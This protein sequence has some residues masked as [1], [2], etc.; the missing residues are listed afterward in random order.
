[1][2]SRADSDDT[3]TTAGAQLQSRR[4][5]LRGLGACVALPAFTS[6]APTRLLAAGATAG[7][8]PAT[9]PPGVPLRSAFISSPTGAIP[10]AWWP[11]AGAAPHESRSLQPLEPVKEFVQVLGQLNHRTAD[12]GPDG[13]G[14]HARGNGTFLTGVRLKKS[15]TDIRAGVSIDQVI[16]R[17]VG[18]LTRFPSLELACET[19]NRKTG[20]CDSGYSCVYQYNLA[21]SSPTMP[22]PPESNP[23]LVFERL[24]GG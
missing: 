12:G 23:R 9:S 19:A 6:L 15:A 2:A 3:T 17:Q 8:R 4:R 20:A 10:S 18:H 24:F 13:A 16:A 22:V 11:K 1:M 7:A 21:W 5:F 14:D